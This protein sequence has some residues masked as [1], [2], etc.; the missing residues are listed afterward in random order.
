MEQ[1]EV[2]GHTSV[3]EGGAKVPMIIEWQGKVQAG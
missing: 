1:V 2:T 3:Y